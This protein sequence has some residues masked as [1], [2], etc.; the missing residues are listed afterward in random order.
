MHPGST[1]L[2]TGGTGLIGSALSAA[3]L[4]RGHHVIILTRNIS[5]YK[6]KTINDKLDYAIWDIQNQTIDIEAVS[7]ADY[8]VHLAGASVAEK[9]W[10]V[11]RK[12]EIRDSRTRSSA[13]LVKALTENK[14][15]VKAVISASGIGWYGESDKNFFTESDPHAKDFLGETCS[16]WEASIDPVQDI[17]IRLVKLRTGIVLSNEGGALKEFKKPVRFGIATIL[18]SGR[19]IVSWIHMDDLVRIYMDAM[20]NESMTGVYNAVAPETVTNKNLVLTIAK[21]WR[22]K[23]FIPFRVP[24]FMLK[25]ILGEMSIEVLKSA[26]VSSNKLRSAGFIFQYPTLASAIGQLASVK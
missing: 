11:K 26:N 1:I 14:H 18:G 7:K 12:N 21:A 17:G 23:F 22:G 13:L 4:Q 20:E 19:Q 6:R 5:N 15:H 16:Q 9:R 10:T 24:T 25:I 2:I 8:I 3:L